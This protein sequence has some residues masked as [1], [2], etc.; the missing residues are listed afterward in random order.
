M[1]VKYTYK[2]IIINPKDK[3]VEVGERYYFGS[4]PKLVL[5]WANR[6]CKSSRLIDVDKEDLEPFS[7]EDQMDYGYSCIIKVKNEEN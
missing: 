2:D 7:S 3:R 6:K 4:N 1:A 5:D